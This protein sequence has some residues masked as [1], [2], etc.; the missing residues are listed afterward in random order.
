VKLL[1]YERDWQ[2][3]WGLLEGDTVYALAGE[4]YDEIRPGARVGPLTD[5]RPLAPCTPATIW[6][7]GAN[8]PSRCDER[9]F[10]YPTVPAVAVVSGSTI[11]GTDVDIA[12]PEFERRSEYGAELGI[13]LK[14]DCHQ[15]EE[16]EAD[17]Y[18]L[19]YT[20]LNN[21]WI[22]DPGEKTAYVRPLRVYDNH[23]PTGPL[24]DTAMDW[25][26]QRVRLWVDGHL[27][28]DDTTSTMFF[29]PHLLISYISKIAPMRRGDLIMTGTPGGVEGHILHYGE[30]VEVEIG[31]LGRLRNR[32]VRVDNAAVTYV[33][34]IHKWV[35][36]QE[37]GSAAA[38]A[39][40]A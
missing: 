13:V 34:S 28:Q 14:R 32:V 11:C 18:I 39:T 9:G 17:D 27:R 38:P 16:A 36:M 5:L 1:R 8:Y 4:P 26:D 30:T 23:C 22:K 2:S 19:G 7:N 25:R 21:I 37:S 31:A 29:S 35:A 24:L 12:I 6:S 3:H 20:A 15:V 40:F 33:V 10:A